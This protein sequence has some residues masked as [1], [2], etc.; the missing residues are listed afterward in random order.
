MARLRHIRNQLKMKRTR[1]VEY[2]VE[3]HP[4]RCRYSEGTTIGVGDGVHVVKGARRQVVVLVC[5]C[6][7]GIC[8]AGVSVVDKDRIGRIHVVSNKS[9][10]RRGGSAEAVGLKEKGPMARPTRISVS[11]I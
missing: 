4:G 3:A 11:S 5:L 9:D 1:T 6:G 2:E 10:R 8:Y 7:I